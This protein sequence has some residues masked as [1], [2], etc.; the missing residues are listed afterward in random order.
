M[1][2]LQKYSAGAT[3]HIAMA[4][5]MQSDKA[6]FIKYICKHNHATWVNIATQKWQ[7]DCQLNL[8]YKKHTPTTYLH[9]KNKK[10]KIK[11]SEKVVS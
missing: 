3:K 8:T 11:S 9:L 2:N 5:G 4:R 1:H 6:S 10:S 7:N